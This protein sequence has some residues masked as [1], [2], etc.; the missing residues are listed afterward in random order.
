MEGGFRFFSWLRW[1]EDLP[2]GANLRQIPLQATRKRAMQLGKKPE[3]ER[4]P[5]QARSP[6]PP[7]SMAAEA[8]RRQPRP[9]LDHGRTTAHRSANTPTISSSPQQPPRPP[10]I[11]S[12]T[13]DHHGSR[14]RHT[15]PRIPH[16]GQQAQR[17]Q[18]GPQRPQ[19]GTRSRPRWTGSS[20]EHMNYHYIYVWNCVLI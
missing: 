11:D 20:S 17:H 1:S 19:E 13:A 4:D 8:A 6:R 18:D 14:D 9:P 3:R 16:R 7:R 15:A 10:S 12:S 5:A 2:P